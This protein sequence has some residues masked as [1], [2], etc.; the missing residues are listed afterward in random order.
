MLHKHIQDCLS[1]LTDVHPCIRYFS[2]RPLNF[3]TTPLWWNHNKRQHTKCSEISTLWKQNQKHHDWTVLYWKELNWLIKGPYCL[4]PRADS[5]SR[6]NAVCEG[7]GTYLESAVVTASLGE[8]RAA[9]PCWGVYFS[10]RD[11]CV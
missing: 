10:I 3:K 6:S 4:A 8:F 11:Y 2:L 1:R 9:E 7:E 5:Y